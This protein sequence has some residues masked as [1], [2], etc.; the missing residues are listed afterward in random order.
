MQLERTATVDV[1]LRGSVAIL[2]LDRPISLNALTPGL[3]NDLMHL[4]D[5]IEQCD[6]I[7]VV[8]LG[9][10][11]KHFMAGGDLDYFTEVFDATDAPGRPQAFAEGLLDVAHKMINRIQQLRQPVIAVARGAAAGFG[12]SLL[13]SCD[14]VVAEPSL[15]LMTAYAKIGVSPDGGLSHMLVSVL[16]KRRAFELLALSS[17][18][19]AEQALSFGLINRIADAEG[20]EAEALAIAEK[21]VGVAPLA[22]S[23][24]KHLV[25]SAEAPSFSAQIVLEQESF[26]ALSETPDFEEGVRAFVEKRKPAFRS[27]QVHA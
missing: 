22:L 21:L 3:C 16:G 25:V 8:L 20:G 12:M 13:L 9:T 27:R 17:A 5:A 18:I 23:A 14:L 11:G 24:I 19:D 6:A 15:T 4:L 2:R 10:T 7:A 26:A 1:E